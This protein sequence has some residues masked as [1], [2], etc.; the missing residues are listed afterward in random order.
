M[1]GIRICRDPR[2]AGGTAQRLGGRRLTEPRLCTRVH[3]RRSARTTPATTAATPPARHGSAAALGG[4]SD[5]QTEAGGASAIA[6]ARVLHGE[7]PDFARPGCVAIVRGFVLL[8]GG[9][10]LAEDEDRVAVCP[11]VAR[12]FIPR[13]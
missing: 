12:W 2:A 10:P 1:V 13:Y 3:R 6:P 4:G 7:P 9:M 8:E 11:V 5:Q